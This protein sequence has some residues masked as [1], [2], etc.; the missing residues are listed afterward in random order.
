[1]MLLILYVLWTYEYEKFAEI[2]CITDVIGHIMH[3]FFQTAKWIA[4][5]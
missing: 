3:I 5:L 2:G 1:M 4:P